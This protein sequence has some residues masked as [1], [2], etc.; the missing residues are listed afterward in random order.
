LAYEA[1]SHL[2]PDQFVTHYAIHIRQLLV[3]PVHYK[4]V[5]VAITI[6]KQNSMRQS[7]SLTGFK[8]RSMQSFNGLNY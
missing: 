5:A 1:E 4:N 6:T 7:E 2:K 8:P 3:T